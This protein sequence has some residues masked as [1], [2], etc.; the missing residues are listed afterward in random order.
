MVSR[1]EGRAVKEY[2]LPSPE[3]GVGETEQP[4]RVKLAGVP[5]PPARARVMG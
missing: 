1:Q 3:S 2:E 5:C 4:E